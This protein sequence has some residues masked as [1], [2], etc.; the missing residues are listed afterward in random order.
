[1]TFKLPIFLEYVVRER[2]LRLQIMKIEIHFNPSEEKVTVNIL[3]IP[4]NHELSKLT[5]LTETCGLTFIPTL[6]NQALIHNSIYYEEYCGR[7]NLPFTINHSSS[8]EFGARYQKW[9][10][11]LIA[12]FPNLNSEFTKAERT[13]LSLIEVS[14]KKKLHQCNASRWNF[15]EF[16]ALKGY[17]LCPYESDKVF[18]P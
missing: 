14:H 1:M 6:G 8:V 7:I 12:N 17:E 9:K 4:G 16:N 10:Q 15:Y 3:E 13:S 5:W 11:I 18:T 2:Y